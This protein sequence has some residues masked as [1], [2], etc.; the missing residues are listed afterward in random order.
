VLGLV[1][2]TSVR[3]HAS[4]WVRL[5]LASASK[6]EVLYFLSKS[7]QWRSLE[8]VRRATKSCG[9]FRE[10]SREPQ[11]F[12]S[13]YEA[14]EYD[15]SGNTLRL[16]SYSLRRA[17]QPTWKKSI[18]FALP[19]LREYFFSL[20]LFQC[21]NTPRLRHDEIAEAIVFLATD[22]SSF[23]HGAVLPVEEGA[24]DIKISFGA[25]PILEGHRY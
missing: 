10:E 25:S 17:D 3:R 23:I 2:K 24:R 12:P 22:R 1:F 6:S 11:D 18:P 15:R 14:T 20:T 5:P 9:Y 16:I 4:R 13:A 21:S 7:A 19:R 8:D